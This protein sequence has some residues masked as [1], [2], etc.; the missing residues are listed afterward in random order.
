MLYSLEHV[1]ASHSKQVQFNIYVDVST[2][3]KKNMIA[4]THKTGFLD[5]Q[6]LQHSQNRNQYRLSFTK[7]DIHVKLPLVQL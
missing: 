2:A 6:Y 5:I 4:S 1:R 3:G 7:N